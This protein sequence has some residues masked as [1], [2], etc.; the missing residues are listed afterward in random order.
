M[1][2]I[3]EIREK[4]LIKIQKHIVEYLEPKYEEILQHSYH[5]LHPLK[6]GNDGILYK[7]DSKW[8]QTSVTIKIS[9]DRNS[10][11]HNFVDIHTYKKE[12]SFYDISAK[13]E[14]W[15]K[16]FVLDWEQFV[17]DVIP[18]NYLDNVTQAFV[19]ETSSK[20]I[21]IFDN[22]TIEE[23]DIINKSI[24]QWGNLIA[25]ELIKSVRN[26]LDYEFIDALYPFAH[27]TKLG[28]Y[29]FGYKP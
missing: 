13:G 27:E 12:K 28:W 5:V 20:E 14:Y 22:F 26:F 21:K 9:L 29:I 15:K 17:L 10:F 19:G 18:W 23:K 4:I 24:E 25:K 3:A 2:I 11:V 1:R 8:N 7:I 16:H 6:K